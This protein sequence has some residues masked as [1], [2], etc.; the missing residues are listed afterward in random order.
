MIRT[1]SKFIILP[2]IIIVFAFGL[3]FG[4]ELIGFSHKYTF[5]GPLSNTQAD[6]PL[7]GFSSHA[8]FEQECGHCHAPLHCVTDTK[9]QDCH[10]E[11]A[12]QRASATGLHSRL[13]GMDTC[14]TCHVEHQGRG[15][16]ITDFAILNIDHQLLAEFSLE[17]HATNF[18]GS[19]MD[20]ESC[21]SK[22]SFTSDTL[23]C[24][25]CH[26][27]ETHDEMASH[28]DLYG[29][30]CVPCHDGSD[31]MADFEH[32]HVYI[33]DGAHQ[34]TECEECHLDRVF[35]GTPNDCASCHEEPEVH[36]GIF[37]T[38]CDRC[39][40]AAAWSPAVLTEHTFLVDHGE[41][42][43]TD[44]ITCETCHVDT[45][46]DYP[47]YSCHDSQEMLDYHAEIEI[48]DAYENCVDCHPTGREGEADQFMQLESGL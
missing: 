37:G 15:A 8:E 26:V 2:G 30:S 17:E 19:P 5:P 35:A 4:K 24:I 14:E 21:H 22:E 1:V 28:I 44:E 10:M 3:F 36:I 12:E 18:D 46:T 23:D 6:E 16:S 7:G 32:A 39:H 42:P 11:I 27:N 25:T 38:K 41:E 9:C 40:V 13:P 48:E 43:R 20:C 45:Y 31:R 33:L 47:C 34:D 29:A